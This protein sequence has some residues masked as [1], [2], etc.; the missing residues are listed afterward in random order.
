[1][2]Y[3]LQNVML[4]PRGKV[5]TE[6][7]CSFFEYLHGRIESNDSH[8]SMFMFRA[9]L[10]IIL[11]CGCNKVSIYLCMHKHCVVCPFFMEI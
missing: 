4:A 3:P 6:L 9:V 10:F 1:M 11:K 2:A 7:Q 8:N 5:N